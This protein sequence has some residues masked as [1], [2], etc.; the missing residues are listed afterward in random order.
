MSTL[1][2]TTINS[3]NGSTDLIIASGNTTAGKVVVSSDGSGLGL[4][5]NSSSKTVAI[6]TSQVNTSVNVAIETTAGIIANGSIGTAGQVLTSNASTVYWSTP[7]VPKG[8]AITGTLQKSSFLDATTYYFGSQAQATLVT[9]ADNNRQYIPVSGNVTAIYL[10]TYNNA[11]VQGTSE[12]IPIYFR[13]NNTTD[14]IFNNIVLNQ[15]SSASLYFT[16]NSINIPVTAGSYFE[17]KQVSPTWVTNPTN[18]MY[19][20]T[21]YIT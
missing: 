12:S 15:A 1:S 7:L 10:S 4:Y 9:V 18:I 8:V 21:V 5:A 2:V 17:F 20:W 19:S 11:G 16:N 3:A 13:Y 14:T 6:S